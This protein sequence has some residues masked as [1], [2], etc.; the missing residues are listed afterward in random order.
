M[1]GAPGCASTGRTNPPLCE[2][3]GRLLGEALTPPVGGVLPV[4]LELYD[5]EGMALGI[6]NAEGESQLAWQA[7]IA[8]HYYLSVT[9]K[10]DMSVTDCNDAP[11]YT[12]LAEAQPWWSLYLPIVLRSH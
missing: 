3:C 11:E 1:L 5:W 7:P 2:I 10:G 6:S 9:P 4:L 8:G 12:L